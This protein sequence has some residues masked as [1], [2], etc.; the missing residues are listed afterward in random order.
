M[1]HGT[2]RYNEF[3]AT[4]NFFS[5]SITF[6]IHS[7]RAL[8]K[9]KNVQAFQLNQLLN[10]KFF[11]PQDRREILLLKYDMWSRW[12]Y[13]VEN[14][15]IECSGNRLDSRTSPE[16]IVLLKKLAEKTMDKYKSLMLDE[17]AI[18]FEP[19][20]AEIWLEIHD[21]VF[22]YFM[23]KIDAFTG[24][25]FDMLFTSVVDVL[26]QTMQ[27]TLIEIHELDVIFCKYQIKCAECNSKNECP[28]HRC[29]LATDEVPFVVVTEFAEELFKS[30]GTCLVCERLKIYKKYFDISD[31][32]I[33]NYTDDFICQSLIERIEDIGY[34]IDFKRSLSKKYADFD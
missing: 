2:E 5:N 27:Y 33:K 11:F 18:K 15:C 9:W 3:L 20:F 30:T 26:I 29:D 13:E 31:I 22:K 21:H 12:L 6:R 25:S 32:Y 16:D 28:K 4:Y 10:G 1:P 8:E 19:K 24:L 17:Y 23:T 34:K 14:F 7:S